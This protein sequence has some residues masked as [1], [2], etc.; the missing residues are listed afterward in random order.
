MEF[1]HRLHR[2]LTLEQCAENFSGDIG[3]ISFIETDRFFFCLGLESETVT[4]ASHWL[5]LKLSPQKLASICSDGFD[6]CIA[7]LMPTFCEHRAATEHDETHAYS[8]SNR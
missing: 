8:E 3:K 2:A 5:Q 1:Q 6:H 4:G 7:T